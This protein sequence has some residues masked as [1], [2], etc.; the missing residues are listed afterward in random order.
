MHFTQLTLNIKLNDTATFENFWA[1]DNLAVINYVRT[2]LQNQSTY[3]PI[4][5]WGKPSSGRTHILQACCHMLKPAIYLPLEDKSLNPEVLENLDTTAL[6]CLDNLEAI[7]GNKAWEAALFNVME[8]ACLF[9]TRLLI[10]AA[11]APRYLKI[12]LADLK[13]RLTAC[14]V[15]KIQALTDKQIV[16]AL[17]MRAQNRGLQLPEQTARFL[18]NTCPRDSKVLFAILERLDHASLISK[19]RLTIPFVKEV[20]QN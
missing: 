13:S 1:G 2:M 18:L 20:M 11:I 19:R 4:Y 5:I 9:H 10:T 14:T 17:M 15:F 7:A 3:S 16:Q 12:A 8:Q 6:I